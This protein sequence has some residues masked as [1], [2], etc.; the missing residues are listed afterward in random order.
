MF[1][2]VQVTWLGHSTFLFETPEGKKILVDPW[3]EGNPKCPEE[4]HDLEVDAI[5]I[6]HGHGDH[7]GDVFTAH[8]RCS[9]P[10]V[11]IFD[12]TTWLGTKG[13]PEDKLV[14]MNKGG[15]VTLDD[16]DV[17]VTMTN[18]H[19]S[20]SFNDDGTI[21]YLGEPAGYVVEFSNHKKFYIAGDTCL[22]GDMA[23]IAELEEPDVAILPIG[24]HFTMDPRRAAHACR[25]L[26][27]DHVIPCHYGT[28]PVLTGTPE[29]LGKELIGQG[30]KT[31]VVALE[32]GDAQG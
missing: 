2:G 14:G 28:F 1:D 19:H 29:Q 31:E 9:G 23:L 11:G 10:I 15:T 13:V 3:L 25:L 32:I 21:V 5:L 8:E 7:I 20:S 27:V 6:T 17:S 26:Q 22:F 24:D 4:F 16:L 18:A 30:L 12:L